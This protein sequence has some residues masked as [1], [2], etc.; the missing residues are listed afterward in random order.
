MKQYGLLDSWGAIMRSYRK[1]EKDI[2]GFQKSF[3]NGLLKYDK[4]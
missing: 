4:I 2:G 1:T 3:L